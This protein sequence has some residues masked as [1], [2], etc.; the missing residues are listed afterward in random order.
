MAINNFPYVDFNTLNLDGILREIQSVK[1]ALKDY[2]AVNKVQF[3][4]NWSIEK[5]YT[6]FSIV[7]DDGT[8]YL[9]LKPVPKGIAVTNT[10]YWTP[11]SNYDAQYAHY[12]ETVN[13]LRDEVSVV[14][15]HLDDIMATI[16]AMPF[17]IRGKNIV[18]V[19]DSW[20]HG[21][22]ATSSASRFSTLLAGYLGMTEFN[23]SV[24]GATLCSGD[25]PQ[26]VVTAS[27]AM[28]ATQRAETAIVFCYAG[29]NDLR[30][31]TEHDTWTYEVFLNAWK[32][33]CAN[34]RQHFPN[35]KIIA[36][37]CN[38]MV[39]YNTPLFR[40]WVQYVCRLL[41]NEENTI[42]LTNGQNIISG[43][44]N[45]YATDGLHPNDV[46][47][48][49][50]ARYFANCIRGG[51][52]RI[53]QYIEK[54]HIT[55][56]DIDIDAN[57]YRHDDIVLV[58]FSKIVVGANAIT[59]NTATNIGSVSV[60][61]APR[62][63]VIIPIFTGNTINGNIQITASG[64]VYINVSATVTTSRNYYCQPMTYHWGQDYTGTP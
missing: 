30:H 16:D 13:A 9:A 60:D 50:L 55:N 18:F 21:S 4:G 2:E 49:M 14:E 62:N 10:E 12:Q 37:P 7:L 54:V 34:A 48:V 31:M 11:T 43:N 56:A 6:S 1:N 20:T 28:T 19:G 53:S 57:V 3:V 33:M 35:A 38:S 41:K 51:S 40:Q 24:G 29:I 64:A 22:G 36:V 42:V 27:N 59:Q 47:H 25:I 5:S 23:Y 39:R 61:L 63:P 26:Q 58:D 8:T 17:V 15:S 44:A 52:D 46:G 45:W 32:T